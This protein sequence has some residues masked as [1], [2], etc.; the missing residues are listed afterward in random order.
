MGDDTYVYIKPLSI[1]IDVSTSFIVVFGSEQKTKFNASISTSYHCIQRDSTQK[2]SLSPI[3][4]RCCCTQFGSIFRYHHFNVFV[5]ELL[6]PATDCFRFLPQAP[7][8]AKATN[9][10]AAAEPFV[11]VSVERRSVGSGSVS[12]F[13]WTVADKEVALSSSR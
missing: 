1:F 9:K 2:E 10:R 6:L 3:T 11:V 4:A 7:I 5:R 13:G 8:T 12:A